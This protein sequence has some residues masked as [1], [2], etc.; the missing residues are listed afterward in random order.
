MRLAHLTTESAHA[1][2][3][4]ARGAA[5]ASLSSWVFGDTRK[6]AGRHRDIRLFFVTAERVAQFHDLAFNEE[7]SAHT[8]KGG[9]CV[10]VASVGHGLCAGEYEEQVVY[11]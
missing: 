4:M 1:E 11:M 6:S 9:D 10:V 8:K 7:V 2:I 3:L 5:G